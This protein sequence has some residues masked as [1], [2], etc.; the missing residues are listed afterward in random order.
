MT[1][2][3]KAADFL[4]EHAIANLEDVILI[5]DTSLKSI[6]VTDAVGTLEVA[7]W[8]EGD[9]VAAFGRI[10]RGKS[11]TEDVEMASE[12]LRDDGKDVESA[13]YKAEESLKKLHEVETGNRLEEI[14]KMAEKKSKRKWYN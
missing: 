10:L 9:V 7:T 1:T 5:L 6:V 2:A 11:Q 3:F 12:A 13:I 14:V 4:S 8:N